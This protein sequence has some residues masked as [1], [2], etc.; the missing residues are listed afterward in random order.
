M[1][2]CDRSAV[3]VLYG[4]TMATF[5]SGVGIGPNVQIERA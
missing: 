4:I 2:E 3:V 1:T 5:L